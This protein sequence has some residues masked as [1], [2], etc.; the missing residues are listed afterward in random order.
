[1]RSR[2][3]QRLTKMNV[4]LHE[5]G[6][7]RAA[8]GV[9]HFANVFTGERTRNLRTGADLDDVAVADQYVAL[10]DPAPR[11][12]RVARHDRSAADERLHRA[13]VTMR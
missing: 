8:T 4:R 11:R 2:S 9:D 6:D 1:M 7:H 12:A 3:Q 10:D 13:H 5:A